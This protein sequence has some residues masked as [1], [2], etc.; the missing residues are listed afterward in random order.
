MTRD[1]RK[2]ARIAERNG[3]ADRANALVVS[4]AKHPNRM[5]ARLRAKQKRMAATVDA[6]IE[7]VARLLKEQKDAKKA[8][9]KAATL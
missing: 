7:R 1:E 4:A 6:G 3:K 2:L 9:K 5:Q 8:A